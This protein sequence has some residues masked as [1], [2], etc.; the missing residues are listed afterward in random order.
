MYLYRYIT[1]FLGSVFFI[2]PSALVITL[3]T[4]TNKEVVLSRSFIFTFCYFKVERAITLN[5]P[6][7]FS[8]TVGE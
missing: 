3:S 8:L 6:T 2:A 4:F 7:L 1:I 5:A